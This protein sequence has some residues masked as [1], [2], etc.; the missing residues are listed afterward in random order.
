MPAAARDRLRGVQAVRIIAMIRKARADEVTRLRTLERAADQAFAELGMAAIAAAEPI[1]PEVLAAYARERRAWVS[2]DRRDRPIA[3]W[4]RRRG[5]PAVTL[6]TFRDVPWNC[7]YYE[8]LGFRVVEQK[9]LTPGLRALVAR[10]AKLGL[11]RWATS[12]H[13]PA[14]RLGLASTR[15]PSWSYLTGVSRA[16]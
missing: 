13:A 8:R 1:A 15:S 11:D 5:L 7:P 9:R 16:A 2:V 6:I 4:A 10:E 14:S 3:R 12:G